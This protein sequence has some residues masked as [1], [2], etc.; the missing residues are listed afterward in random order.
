MPIRSEYRPL[1]QQQIDTFLDKAIFT[2][3]DMRTLGNY[4]VILYETANEIGNY[5]VSSN[6]YGGLMEGQGVG[7]N[8]S[9]I[10]PVSIGEGGHYNSNVGEIEFLTIIFNDDNEVIELVDNKNGIILSSSLKSN[11]EIYILDKEDKIIF[12]KKLY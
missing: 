7:L 2:V 8:N 6:Q 5:T 1:T 4:T 3:L 12:S 9:K 10:V 11:K